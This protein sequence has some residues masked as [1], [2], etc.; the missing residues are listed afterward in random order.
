MSFEFEI[1]SHSPATKPKVGVLGSGDVAKVL[2]A[3]FHKHGYPAML[4]SR[5]PT[6]L[7]EWVSGDG[8]GVSA[9]TFAEAAEFGD[10]LILAV[11]GTAAAACL[12][13]CGAGLASKVVMD[14]TNPII[15]NAPMPPPGGIVP[16]FKP[17]GYNSLMEALQAEF[18]DVKF[19]KA[20]NTMGNGMMIDPDWGE[21]RGTMM[22][23][24]N[25]AD[26]KVMVTTMVQEVGHDVE[27][28]G[29]AEVAGPLES[30]CQ[31]WCSR[32]FNMGKWMHAFRLLKK[33]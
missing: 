12:K 8:A 5:D 20:F 4:S 25:D 6:K 3:G 9:G 22:I 24:G 17:E 29:G 11:K 1:F 31:L 33:D 19:V 26:A 27:D 14:A 2:A 7:A 21:E 13:A 23:C 28:F 30:I 18:A 32:G 16:F 10:V 15:D